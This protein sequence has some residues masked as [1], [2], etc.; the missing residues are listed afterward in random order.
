MD[1]SSPYF[2]LCEAAD[3]WHDGEDIAPL[4]EVTSDFLESWCAVVEGI[5]LPRYRETALEG[6]QM[7]AESTDVLRLASDESQVERALQLAEQ[8]QELLS[9][10][11]RLAEESG[12]GAPG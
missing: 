2:V 4:L 8:G 1:S 3:R 7:L 6:L 12:G 11:L 5:E 9:E 10:A